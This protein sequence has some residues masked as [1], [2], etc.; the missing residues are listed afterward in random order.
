M[1]AATIVA[2]LLLALSIL[3]IAFLVLWLIVLRDSHR[4]TR[5]KV[6]ELQ[7]RMALVE[8]YFK[9]VRKLEKADRKALERMKEMDG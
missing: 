4:E 2:Y 8:K 7:N 3:A 5:A 9:A 6:A 1:L